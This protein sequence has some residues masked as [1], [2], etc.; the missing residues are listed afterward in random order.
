M[1]LI[2]VCANLAHFFGLNLR[3]GGR[4]SLIVSVGLGFSIVCRKYFVGGGIYLI[5]A[6]CFSFE[7]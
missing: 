2:I 1:L 7:I 4:F 6:S 5:G 3:Q